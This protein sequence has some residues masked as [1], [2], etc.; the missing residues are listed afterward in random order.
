L[1]TLETDSARDW[2]AWLQRNHLNKREVWLVFYKERLKARSVSYDEAL[3]EALAYGWIDSLIRKIDEK[4]YARKFT[5]RR[6]GSIWSR[7]NVDRV[8]R[9][10][11]EGRM[12]EWGLEAFSKRTGKISMMEKVSAEGV[13]IPADLESAL[14]KDKIAWNNFEKFTIG[15]RKK[16]LVWISSAKRAETRKKRIGEAVL[17]ISRNVKNLPK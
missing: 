9:L 7:I 1:E 16:Y 6:P 17:M 5:P 15:Y 14:R 12:T 13:T 3:D 8:N 10:V 11:K 2:R 4:K